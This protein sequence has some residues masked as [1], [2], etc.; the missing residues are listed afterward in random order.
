[1]N[2][3]LVN[4]LK[5]M[6]SYQDLNRALKYLADQSANKYFKKYGMLHLAD[7][8]DLMK[9]DQYDLA[10]DCFYNKKQ[11]HCKDNHELKLEC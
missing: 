5:E 8:N 6:Y 4:F 9:L 7:D 11:R 1:M 10:Q 3:I 2:K